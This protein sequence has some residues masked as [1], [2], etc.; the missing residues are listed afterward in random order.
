MSWAAAGASRTT[1]IAS[2]SLTAGANSL[3]SEIDNTANK[4]RWA[5]LELTFTCSTAATARKVV[6]AYLIYATDGTNY[7][8][9]DGTP[10]D[11][12]KSPAG[13]FVNRNVTTQQKTT[14]TGIPLEPLKFKLLLKSELNQDATSLTLLCYTYNE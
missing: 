3:G 13:V 6:E 11:P 12:A 2:A 1:G 9:G 10:T 4:D 8:D 5:T 7:E 14:I